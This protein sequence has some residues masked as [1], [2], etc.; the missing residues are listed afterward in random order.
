M[1]KPISIITVNR[2]NAAGLRKTLESTAAQDSRDFEQIVIDGASTDESVDVIRE[3]AG[4]IDYWVSEPDKGAYQAMNKGIVAAKGDYCL[5]INSG[6][7]LCDERV[8]GRLAETIKT[9][10]DVY[11]ADLPSPDGSGRFLRFPEKVGLGFFISASLSHQNAMIRKSCLERCGLY[12][13]NNKIMSDWELFLKASH[14]GISSFEHIDRPIAYYIHEGM[15]AD[16]GN[17][18]L[19][20]GEV[21]RAL[22]SEFGDELGPV[23]FEYYQYKHSVYHGILELSGQAKLFPFLLK[24]YRYCARRMKK[25]REIFRR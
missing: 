18:S 13:E 15:S 11:Y 10:K 8:S 14:D 20:I 5:F 25:L 2:N 24:S 17:S 16:P 1:T 9:G 7:W 12:N 3:Y 21:K 6:D 22:L 23:L 19:R 4:A